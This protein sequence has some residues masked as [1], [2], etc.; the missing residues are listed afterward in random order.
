MHAEEQLLLFY[1]FFDIWAR[2]HIVIMPKKDRKKIYCIYHAEKPE[3]FQAAPKTWLVFF[4]AFSSVE[5]NTDSVY[6]TRSVAGQ[7]KH[8]IGNF[9]GCSPSA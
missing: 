4:A 5:S 8:G 6:I 3:N 1:G 9:I 7:I 2:F